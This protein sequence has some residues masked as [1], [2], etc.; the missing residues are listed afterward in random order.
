[1]P[2]CCRTAGAGTDEAGASA[3][4][5]AG[6][7]GGVATPAPDGGAGGTTVDAGPDPLVA[8]G[9]AVPP[10]GDVAVALTG[11]VGAVKVTELVERL[12]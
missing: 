12:R 2:C 4:A 1:M 5:G 8:G 11:A 10:D 6:A 7:A 9:A 3:T